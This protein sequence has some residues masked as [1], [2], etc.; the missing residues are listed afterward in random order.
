LV[1]FGEVVVTLELVTYKEYPA[2]RIGAGKMK[3]IL[4]SSFSFG[5]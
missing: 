5:S 2:R 1:G 4:N 3:H